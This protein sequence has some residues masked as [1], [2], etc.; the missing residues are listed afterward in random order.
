MGRRRRPW[1]RDK[2]LADRLTRAGQQAFRRS[3]SSLS[4]RR[5]LE[6]SDLFPVGRRPALSRDAS[7]LEERQCAGLAATL[8]RSARLTTAPSPAR[9]AVRG[10]LADRWIGTIPASTGSSAIPTDEAS[11]S[12]PASLPLGTTSACG[13]PGSAGYRSTRRSRS[14]RI[15]APAGRPHAERLTDRVPRRS[16]LVLAEKQ[17]ADPLQHGCRSLISR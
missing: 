9:G 1:G 2:V 17:G 12:S 8:L 14:S 13:H 15:S 16:N 10:T 11:G 5:R 6:R 3:R 7:F 4:S